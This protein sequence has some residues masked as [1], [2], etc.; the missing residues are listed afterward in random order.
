MRN[1]G[2]AGW[3][4]ALVG[5]ANLLGAAAMAGDFPLVGALSTQGLKVPFYEE[6]VP[7]QNGLR[8]VMRGDRLGLA[9]AEG[10]WVLPPRYGFALVLGPDRYLVW[11]DMRYG[12]GPMRGTFDL[13]QPVSVVDGR[14]NRLDEAPALARELKWVQTTEQPGYFRYSAA[15]GQGIVSADLRVVVPGALFI[16]DGNI[17]VSGQKSFEAPRSSKKNWLGFDLQQ[18]SRVYDLQGNLLSDRPYIGAETDDRRGFYQGYAVAY[19]AEARR[20]GYISP[21]GA[22]KITPEFY[23]ATPFY[24]PVAVVVT[25]EKDQYT[26]KGALI[27]RSG[28][29]I[30]SLPKARCYT[31]LENGRLFAQTEVGD[32]DDEGLLLDARGKKI[33]TIPG[34][35]CNGSPRLQWIDDRHFLFGGEIYDADGRP[36]RFGDY[37]FQYDAVQRADRSQGLLYVRASEGYAPRSLVELRQM[38]AA[39]YDNVGLRPVGGAPWQRLKEPDFHLYDVVRLY[40]DESWR[41]GDSLDSH[42]VT[43][44]VEVKARDGRSVRDPQVVL[45]TAGCRPPPG[46]SFIA[47]GVLYPENR[48]TDET[49]GYPVYTAFWKQKLGKKFVLGS[50]RG[51]PCDSWKLIDGAIPRPAS[52]AQP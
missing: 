46:M 48:K 14:G 30:A 49:V 44:T 51:I 35:H 24:D 42:L 38:E 29:Q 31:P 32:G 20:F 45:A 21:D 27:D 1:K 18:V 13:I 34:F 26:R 19:D 43:L 23:R 47:E 40:A 6:L 2:I 39:Y 11:D 50:Q 12:T 37:P 8:M 5:A 4:A 10:N 16:E 22:W 7:P 52:G 15:S 3:V 9:D 28:Q 41:S 17:L 36:S 25:D 33:A